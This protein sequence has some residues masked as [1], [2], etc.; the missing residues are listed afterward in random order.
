MIK[1]HIKRS[2]KSST[3]I[4]QNLN[5]INLDKLYNVV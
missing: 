2:R 3:K 5:D 1:K 4:E